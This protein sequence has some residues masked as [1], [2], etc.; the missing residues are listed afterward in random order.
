MLEAVRRIE[1]AHRT[2]SESLDMRGLGLTVI[3]DSIAELVNLEE[4]NLSS[5]R[6]TAIPDSIAELESLQK[7]YLGK[8]LITTIPDSLA[9]L[10]NLHSLY[11]GTNRITAIPNCLAQLPN[12]HTLSL[13]GNPLPEEVFAALKRGL[14]SFRRY[15]QS[16]ATRRVYPRTVKLVLLGEPRSGKTTLLEALKGNPHPC[17]DSRKETLGVDVVNIDKLHPVGREPIHLSVWDFAGQHIEHATHQF[18]L[19]E[20][21]IYLI[22]WNAR[23]G[24]ESGKHDLWYWLELLRMRVRNPKFLLVATHTEHTPPD[25]NLSTIKKIYPGCEGNFP[26][27]LENL[28][29]VDP[30]QTKIL[31]LAAESPSLRAEWPPEWLSVRDEVRKI[32]KPYM[33]PVAFDSLMKKKQVT[34][35]VEQKDLAGQLHNLGEILCYQER[36]EL[37]R[38]VILNPEWVTELIA[39]VVRSKEVREDGG[40]LSKGD[41]AKLWKQQKLRPEVEEHLIHLMDWFDLT[42]ATGHRT[43]LGIVVEALPYS[44]PEDIERIALPKDQPRMEMIFR[45]PSLQRRLPPGIPTWGIARAHRFSKCKPWRDAAVFEDADSK[46]QALVLASEPRKEIRLSVAADYPPFFFGVM[47]S[48]LQDTFKRYPGA[49]P[50]RHL[51]CSCRPDCPETHLYE[52][53][54]KR[55]HDRKP[56]VMCK[57]SGEDVAIESLLSGAGRP[58]TEEGLRAMQSE[59]RRLFTA[60]MCA[61][62]E[63]MEKTCPSVFTLIPSQGFKQ[64]DTWLDSITQGE[65][66]DLVL[67]CEHDSG[68]HATAYSIYRFTLDQDWFD[69]LKGRWNRMVGITR[70]VGPLAKAF[71]IVTA[72]PWTEAAGVG[73]EKLPEVSRSAAGMLMRELGEPEE[74]DLVDIETR[75]LLERLIDHLDSK[76]SA[77][78]PKNG[79][80]HPYLIEDGRLLWLCPEHLKKYKKR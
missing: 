21:A 10:A 53:V 68:W 65:E 80:L 26:V 38:L 54:L 22:L 72:T 47:Q 60:Q 6:I 19:T 11:L 35:P 24:P 23:Q 33:T 5:N 15:L 41:L 1:M 17:D 71:G 59:M 12:L 4:L 73:I 66:L 34:Q 39:L 2:M 75:Y 70:Y 42:Y 36:D 74:P 18:F 62:R 13:Y 55:W 43:E 16:T 58:E 78:D 37:S 9:R 67:Y 77:T 45:F 25:I 27:E 46:S 14:P 44:T 52:T 50:E 56:N 8:N 32:G 51:P 31:E 76:R 49:L 29:G 48:I 69:S 57:T 63:Q 30:L 64:L 40:I 7:L 20:N 28:K 61:Q 3:P 79:G